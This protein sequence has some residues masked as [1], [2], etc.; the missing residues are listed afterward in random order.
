MLKR[1]TILGNLFQK[2]NLRKKLIEELISDFP[3]TINDFEYTDY[4]KVHTKGTASE[5]ISHVIEN[6]VDIIGKRE[7]YIEYISKRPRVEKQG[8]HGLFTDDKVPI[9]L[10]A[11]AKEVANHKGNVW[12]DIMSLRRE[13]AVRL[14]YDKGE[15]WRNLIRTQT[16]TIA[17]SMKIP[18]EDLRWY[19][20]FHNES[21][22]PHVHIVAYSV[23]KEP[24]MSEQGILEMKSAFAREIF[25]QNLIQVYTEQTKQRNI[26][27][28]ESKDILSGI[29]EDIS[30]NG[31]NNETIELM[32]KKLSEQL[33]NT[34][35]KKVYGYLPQKTRNLVNG[36]IDELEKDPRIKTLYDLWYKQREEFI[37]TYTDNILERIPL[38]KNN[39]F[40]TIKNAVIQEALNILYDHATFKDNFSESEN[41]AYN[42]SEEQDESKEE[43]NMNKETTNQDYKHSKLKKSSV[44]GLDKYYSYHGRTTTTISAFRLLV[45]LSQMFQDRLQK[46]NMD[47]L[48]DKKLS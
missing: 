17:T 5:F 8:S 10:S 48:T 32:L 34:K 31:Y 45:Q 25:K 13:D 38:S 26:L 37:R 36:I 29:A 30:D 6:N 22:H 1:L 7:N 43:T 39:E 47:T 20:A 15:S 40:K 27:K 41:L 3:D 18:L 21:Y 11:V 9:N 35:G 33:A 46:D 28:G 4:I 19:A 14:G 2:L 42:I 24:Y 16:E 23:G 12:T 44:N